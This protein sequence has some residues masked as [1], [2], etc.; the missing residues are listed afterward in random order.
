MSA[1]LAG[2][3]ILVL[4]LCF[5]VMIIDGFDAQAVGFVAPSFRW[6]G[7]FRK[8]PSARCSSR[9]FSGWPL[10]AAVR[11]ACRSVRTQDHHHSLFPGVRHSYRRQGVRIVHRRSQRFAATG[12]T[13][14]RWRDAECHCACFGVLTGQTAFADDSGGD[15]RILGGRQRCRIF[16]GALGR[17]V[18]LASYISHRRSRGIGDGAGVDCAAARINSLHGAVW[19]RSFEAGVDLKEDRPALARGH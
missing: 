17:G 12:G 5:I 18:W 6:N 9:V 4:T 13:W 15:R 8:L 3:Q 1:A 14:D 19:S 2:F 10:S 16:N 7:R 11:R